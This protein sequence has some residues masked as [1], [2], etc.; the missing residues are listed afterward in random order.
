[1]KTTNQN[2]S[3][4]NGRE[5]GASRSAPASQQMSPFT[6]RLRGHTIHVTAGD[7][8]LVAALLQELGMLETTEAFR[9]CLPCSPRTD[10]IVLISTP[11]GTDDRLF[12]FLAD[13]PE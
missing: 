10:K 1:M 13:F 9:A 3:C 8:Y 5:V 6:A 2:E 12:D 11:R 7:S 4:E